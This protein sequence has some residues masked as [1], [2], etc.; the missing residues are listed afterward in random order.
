MMGYFGSFMFALTLL[1]QGGIGLSPLAAGLTFVPDN[2][3]GERPRRDGE[4]RRSRGARNAT[5]PPRHRRRRGRCAGTSRRVA[6]DPMDVGSHTPNVEQAGEIIGV[7]RDHV[8][9]RAG[10]QCDVAVHDVGGTG[11]A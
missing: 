10:E 8:I 2:R 3:L 11:V 5:D 9:S 4:A 7:G 1:L 6:S